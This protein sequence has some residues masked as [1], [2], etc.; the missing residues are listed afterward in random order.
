MRPPDYLA[1]ADSVYLL[2]GEVRADDPARIVPLRRDVPRNPG[3]K[4]WLVVRAERL[5]WSEQAYAD[6]LAQV[7]RWRAAGNPVEGVQ[8]DFDA[9]TLRLGTYAAFL[10]DLRQRMPPD[11]KL[12]ATGLMDWSAGAS[13]DDLA[14]LSEVLD[15]VVVQTY[16]G[17]S[18]IPGYEAYLPALDR[19]EV[20]FRVALVEGGEWEAPPSLAANPRFR[21][22]V[23]FLLTS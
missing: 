23:V 14:S 22:Y 11:L 7:Q 16:Q 13:G 10:R 4:I 15:E 20:P 12:S 3:P 17:R 2:W 21:G 6:L 5:D 8:I 19:L 1:Q 18:T 9:A